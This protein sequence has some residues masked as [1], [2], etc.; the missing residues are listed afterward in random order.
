[1]HLTPH[2]YNYILVSLSYLVSVL[3]SFTGL[4]ITAGIKDI[5]DPARRWK[6][7]I[8]ASLV[9]GMG[10]IWTM[11]FIGMLAL[12]MPVKVGYGV[13]LT[14]LS[15]LVAVV[16]CLIGLV[17]TSRGDYSTLN[18]LTAGT[19]MGIG[20]AAMH[21]MG[22]AA[23]RMPATTVYDGAITT[24]SIVIAV[25]ASVAALWMGYRRSS[26]LQS[27]FGS[28]V[29]GLAV[30][31]MHYTGMAAARFVLVGHPD[32]H[33]IESIDSLLMGTVVFGVVTVLL[34]GVLVAA[35]RR[36]RAFAHGS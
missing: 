24:L 3:G 26:V 8:L 9:M 20:V 32:T 18:L 16:A 21:Y 36:P 1:M 10:A 13:G 33:A 34:G 4:R 6:R 30:C 14:S 19:Y 23:M 7:L 5:N 35:L 2:S 15:A 11:H 31:G 27:F 28:L 17:M 29:M 22:M 25:V 12:N